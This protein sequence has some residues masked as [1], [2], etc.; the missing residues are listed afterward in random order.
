ML[1]RCWT[2]ALATSATLSTMNEPS[3]SG[4]SRRKKGGREGGR[5][6]GHENID[7]VCMCVC[8]C[9]CALHSVSF[10]MR[11]SSWENTYFAQFVTFT[12]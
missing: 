8:V 7:V 2:A 4:Y 9:V 5:E 11:R 6:G 1:F 12:V 3:V 10:K